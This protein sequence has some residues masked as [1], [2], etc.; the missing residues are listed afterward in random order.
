MATFNRI[1]LFAIMLLAL[2]A[3]AL[4]FV[5]NQNRKTMQ[6]RAEILA[7]TVNS[8]TKTLAENSQTKAADNVTFTPALP[9]AGEPEQGT[10]GWINFLQDKENE[11]NNYRKTVDQAK[12]LAKNIASQRNMMADALAEIGQNLNSKQTE[13]TTKLTNAQE[14]E[15]AETTLRNIERLSAAIRKRDMDLID[16]FDEIAGAL[17]TTINKTAFLTRSEQRDEDGNVYYGT[18]EHESELPK[19]TKAASSLEARTEEYAN[20]LAGMIRTIQNHTWS[21]SPFAITDKQNYQRAL[22]SIVNDLESINAELLQAR[23]SEAQI[24][25]LRS[26]MQEIEKKLNMTVQERN[27]LM[28]DIANAKAKLNKAADTALAADTQKPKTDTEPQQ[29]TPTNTGKVVYVNEDFGFVVVDMGTNDQ[30]RKGTEL[31]LAR[32]GEFVARVAVTEVRPDQAVAELLPK[33]MTGMAKL[34]DLAV[35]PKEVTE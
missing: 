10:L 30:V 35:P 17:D 12:T 31:L 16:A 2:T 24:K 15:K 6:K 21:V 11:F 4:T 7:E 9:E 25:K 3:A 32:D 23:Q 19:L 26:E 14:L 13:I 22:T 1:L 29:T 18:F 28:K 27:K 33:A 5:L 34:G 20:A 8:I